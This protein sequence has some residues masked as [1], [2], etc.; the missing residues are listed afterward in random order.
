MVNLESWEQLIARVRLG[1][2][3]KRDTYFAV[4]F[5]YSGIRSEEV[6]LSHFGM[7]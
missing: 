4:M 6:S 2:G 5:I 1:Y 3:V 7:N